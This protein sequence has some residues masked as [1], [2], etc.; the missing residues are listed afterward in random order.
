MH[1]AVAE[2]ERLLHRGDSQMTTRHAPPPPIRQDPQHRHA[3]QNG[4]AEERDA[5]ERHAWDALA[6]YKFVMFGYWCGIWVHLNRLCAIPK[7]NPW[8]ELVAAAR[9]H[10]RRHD[11]NGTTQPSR[12]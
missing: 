2:A 3:S 1:G 4:L 10:R 5:A 7:P 8:K 9:R 12:P 6:R 11:E